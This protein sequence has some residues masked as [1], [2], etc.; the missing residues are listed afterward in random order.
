[1]VNIGRMY[2]KGIGVDVDHEES[3]RWYLK[4]VKFLSYKPCLNIAAKYI[5]GTGVDKDHIIAGMWFY[6]EDNF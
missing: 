3:L 1:M 4:S 6:L 2:P 5:N